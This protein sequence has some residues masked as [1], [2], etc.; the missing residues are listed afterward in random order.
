MSDDEGGR[1]TRSR[2]RSKSHDDGASNGGNSLY[3]AGLPIRLNKAE[4]EE[5]FAKYGRLA[6]CD[7]IEDPITH[8]SRGF[9]FVVY[10]DKRDAED[11]LNALNDKEVYGKRIRVEKSKRS[12]PHAKSPGQWPDKGIARGTALATG[13]ETADRLLGIVRGTVAIDLRH[14]AIVR[15]T[16]AS[17]LVTETIAATTDKETDPATVVAKD[18]SSIAFTSVIQP[19]TET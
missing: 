11:A 7:L 13:H 1:G 3:A 17:V 8:E 16:A 14:R 9:G 19:R 15:A 4:F 2:S 12:K 5:L 10:E 6:S 18:C